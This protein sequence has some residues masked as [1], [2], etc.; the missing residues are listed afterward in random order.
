M[1]CCSLEN[2]VQGI[3]Y[4]LQERFTCQKSEATEEVGYEK[5]HHHI[6]IIEDA[7]PMVAGI[8]EQLLTSIPADLVARVK[9][10]KSKKQIV[11]D[12][13]PYRCRLKRID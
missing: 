9:G 6:S 3:D 13:Y 2:T 1:C 4:V 10:T 7:Y 8:D 12:S 5:T 11:R